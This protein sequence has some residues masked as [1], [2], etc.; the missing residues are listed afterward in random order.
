MSLALPQ[1]VAETNIQSASTGQD[2]ASSGAQRPE[3]NGDERSAPLPTSLQPYAK[4]L[5]G[6]S[7]IAPTANDSLVD[8]K[9]IEVEQLEAELAELRRVRNQKLQEWNKYDEQ[10]VAK[11]NAAQ[12]K[13]A[14][15]SP[16]VAKRPDAGYREYTQESLLQYY[17]EKSNTLKKSLETVTK[18]L[19]TTKHQ[20]EFHKLEAAQLLGA[21][22][23]LAATSAKLNTTEEDLRQSRRQLN[24][25]N[26]AMARSQSDTWNAVRPSLRDDPRYLH[27][28]DDLKI[29]MIAVA[30]SYSGTLARGK[31]KMRP[32]MAG[33]FDSSPLSGIRVLLEPL[34]SNGGDGVKDFSPIRK[35]ETLKYDNNEQNSASGRDRRTFSVEKSTI[36]CPPQKITTFNSP[37]RSL[38]AK[39][40]MDAGKETRLEVFD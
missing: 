36:D 2:D 16:E 18:Q 37:I 10:A 30:W 27:G 17:A 24:Q 20:K 7:D 22:H 23:Q 29:R 15:I 28:L 31:W 21:D 6:R 11:I 26:T 32:F 40:F 34:A 8:P 9:A 1:Y 25:S 14:A 4:S 35:A 38:R 3:T 12:K 5:V 19:E 33:A 13:L 39:T